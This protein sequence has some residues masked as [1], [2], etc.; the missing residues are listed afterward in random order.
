MYSLIVPSREDLT[1]IKKD[2]G[3]I[4]YGLIRPTL[5]AKRRGGEGIRFASARPHQVSKKQLRIVLAVHLTLTG[6]V[7]S[8]S[9]NQQRRSSDNRKQRTRSADNAD[10]TVVR[11]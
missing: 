3:G 1:I 4:L 11:R 10:C 5:S 2:I 6:Q 8:L 9:P 7:P